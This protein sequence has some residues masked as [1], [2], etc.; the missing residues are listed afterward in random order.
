M[1]LAWYIKLNIMV[2]GFLFVLFLIKQSNTPAFK[3]GL[4]GLF[5]EDKGRE[6]K[7][8]TELTGD[9]KSSSVQNKGR[10]ARIQILDSSK[11]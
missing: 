8:S 6:N 9:K 10:K 11:K 3:L 4:Q 2:M 1:D 7:A 5:T